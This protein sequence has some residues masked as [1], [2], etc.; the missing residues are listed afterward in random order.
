MKNVNKQIIIGY[1]GKDAEVHDAN[2]TKILKFSVAASESYKKGEEVVK[3]TTWF[4]VISFRPNDFLLNN[5][6]KGSPVY[7]EGKT[8]NRTYTES[9]VT[10]NY[11]EV[12]AFSIIPLG[13]ITNGQATT[14][15]AS[16]DDFVESPAAGLEEND[17]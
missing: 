3:E 7:V 8:N 13:L 6:K 11:S 5:L 12:R 14:D 17:F 16:T 4:N 1:L 9:N 15:A 2:G 10:K